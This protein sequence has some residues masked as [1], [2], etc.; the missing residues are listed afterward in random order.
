M[1]EISDSDKSVT[2]FNTHGDSPVDRVQVR[3]LKYPDARA[4]IQVTSSKES[5]VVEGWV[6]C[7]R[8][9]HK[10][11]KEYEEGNVTGVIYQNLY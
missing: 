1:F 6:D 4:L 10:F 5:Q 8:S 3:N 7:T 9:D 11:F 2:S